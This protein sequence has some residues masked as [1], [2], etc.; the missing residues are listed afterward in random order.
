MIVKLSEDRKR[1]ITEINK[2]ERA[3]NWAMLKIALGIWGSWCSA[4]LIMKPS[5]LLYPAAWLTILGFF[6]V[7]NLVYDKTYELR[8]R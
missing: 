8:H 5:L 2:N 1:I 3:A 7:L 6:Y 4:A